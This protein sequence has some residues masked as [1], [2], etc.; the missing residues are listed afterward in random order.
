MQKI[1]FN[2]LF[3]KSKLK[4]LLTWCIIN[5]GQYNTLNL[6]ENLKQL[7][8]KYATIAGISLGIDD[9]KTIS[10]KRPLII[11]N[12]NNIQTINDYFELGIINEVDK[13]QYLINNWQKISEIL[14]NDINKK[15]KNVHRLNPIYMM[16]FSGAR[17][18][19]SQVRQLIG[20][21]GLM[22]DPNGQIIH[23]PITSNFREGL[24]V[25]E[26]LIS[27]YGARKGVVDTALRTA[28]AGYLT[29]RLVDT[30]QHVIISQL[31]CMTL[32]GIFLSNL[33]QNEN[34]ITSLQE[35]LYGRILAINL[36]S[37][38]KQIKLLRN[39]QIDNSLAVFL[40][41]NFK[42]IYVRSALNCQAS[43]LT[44]CQLCYG[45]NLSHLRLI[46]LGEVVG[47]VAAQSIGEPGTQLTMRT[48]H[49][50]GV[51]SGSAI[52]HLYAP[53]KGIVNYS[54]TLKGT[55][56]KTYDNKVLLLVQKTGLIILSPITSISYS[57]GKS[58]FFRE[59]SYKKEHLSKK[60][61]AV[62]YTMLFVKNKEIVEYN[63]LIAK[64]HTVQATNQQIKAVYYVLSKI[65]G[66]VF[67]DDSTIFRKKNTIQS[68]LLNK[69]ENLWILSGK[70]YKPSLELRLFP[71]TG[72]LIS[73][74]FPVA[75]I[76][77]LNTYPSFFRTLLINKNTII[78]SNFNTQNS[79]ALLFTD[80][81]IYSF[82][83]N[84]ITSMSQYFIIKPIP[85]NLTENENT[86]KIQSFNKKKYTFFSSS[87]F[88]AKR[89]KINI[90]FE[91]L[92]QSHT[93]LKQS[94]IA[95]Y[96]ETT[97]KENK[98]LFL[99][100]SNFL[101]KSD[102]KVLNGLIDFSILVS[103]KFY[104]NRKFEE[105]NYSSK[106]FHEDYLSLTL[107][108][109]F[110]F[111]DE[112]MFLKKQ[113]LN[114]FFKTS[115][116]FLTNN[117]LL[118]YEY[119]LVNEKN[120]LIFFPKTSLRYFSPNFLL[121]YVTHR[122]SNLFFSPTNLVRSRIKSS[123][124]NR[125]LFI[126]NTVKEVKFSSTNFFE[127]LLENYI[128]PF[129]FIF[130]RNIS[131]F[132]FFYLKE[133]LFYQ[134]LIKT[135]S[136][137]FLIS[138][139]MINSCLSFLER[140]G[141]FFYV[142]IFFQKEKCCKFLIQQVSYS[143]IL[144]NFED[145]PILTIISNNQL[146]NQMMI[147]MV[148]L[149]KKSS[150]L[151]YFSSFLFLET[152]KNCTF[153]NVQWKKIP[154]FLKSLPKF[155]NNFSKFNSIEL[156]SFLNFNILD[157]W[158]I[159]IINF[160]KWKYLDVFP[161]KLNVECLY[162]PQF[163][164]EFN[165][166]SKK[167]RFWNQ[168]EKKIVLK[169]YCFL[170][171]S[172]PCSFSIFNFLR[173]KSFNRKT[174]NFQQIFPTI[175]YSRNFRQNFPFEKKNKIFL[176]LN[177]HIVTPFYCIVKLI[178][179]TF[180]LSHTNYKKLFLNYHDNISNFLLDRQ[181]KESFFKDSLFL[182]YDEL[183]SLD[184]FLFNKKKSSRLSFSNFYKKVKV[185][186]FLQIPLLIQSYIYKYSYIKKF[187]IR[188]QFFSF[189]PLQIG[190]IITK[191][192]FFFPK[193]ETFT[194]NPRLNNFY[195]NL[196][197]LS[198]FFKCSVNNYILRRV[199]DNESLHRNLIDRILFSFHH[200]RWVPRGTEIATISFLSP[201]EGEILFSKFSKYSNSNI[202]FNQ[203]II[204][205]KDDINTVSIFRNR[206]QTT[207]IQK[208]TSEIRYHINKAHFVDLLIDVGSL[209]Y[210]TSLLSP[211]KKLAQSGQLV[212]F[213][214]D[215]CILRKGIP[216]LYPLNGLF[217]VWNGDFIYVNSPIMTLL[218]S[219][220]K[221]GDIVQGI[222]KIEHFF[223]ARKTL[224]GISN[225]LQSNIYFKLLVIF[226]QFKKQLSIKRA[227]KRSVAKIQKIIID[228]VLRVYC[229]QGISI[230]RKHFEVIIRQM[231]SKA[232]II[233]GGETGLIEGELI[234][235]YKIDKINTQISFKRI[236]Y[237]PIILGITKTSLK[238]D[239]FISS[240]SF[241]ETARVLS[242][243]AI[244]KKIDFLNGL[245]E[246][247]ILGRLIP[248]G[249]GIISSILTGFYG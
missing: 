238:T 129:L 217:Y 68:L 3:N 206:N 74:G 144:R 130:N 4:T 148:P 186:Y 182:F 137:D 109:N 91:K 117:F 110:V 1:F 160:L 22:A 202:F 93:F 237:E 124:S 13:S 168:L 15:F 225:G 8:F 224:K 157:G 61:E 44:I 97:S 122:Q 204:L 92:E 216:L 212:G 125:Q 95:E 87:S 211:G 72:D 65:E 26:Y 194:I 18:N 11:K 179:S 163:L 214:K 52:N 189:K 115:D 134:Q 121:R 171:V 247:V 158:M 166:V 103:K 39:K 248:G 138:V 10:T 48:F 181:F 96:S 88:C 12:Y 45:W 29:R 119:V 174:T 246:N 172:F 219:K 36:E 183:Y 146:R 233:D 46:S 85:L 223:E 200:L 86:I 16:A 57:K 155:E 139:I 240:A 37:N 107:N 42:R 143:L 203:L 226:M 177:F 131:N 142:S 35:Q 47:I 123:F 14:K 192:D 201:Y 55:T 164:R 80:C 210:S 19:I 234:S 20:M 67:I 9:F 32:K 94:K 207:L 27:C 31:D 132:L 70:I 126:S 222:P 30:A 99:F 156:E 25:T 242:Q 162:I 82:I 195:I 54:A 173:L 141:R 190:N 75:K 69:T 64:K 66:E 7:G 235:L 23:L 187:E 152:R 178:K 105:F 62:P 58:L 118:T 227:I 120:K 84:N 169:Y 2:S 198:L 49:T 153:L 113:H 231:T 100:P 114:I 60:F 90:N 196:R 41:K 228:G 229:S 56:I 40:S 167:F 108:N 53:F 150:I 199:F 154:F 185:S 28:T 6:A 73:I 98:S 175:F 140:F 232:K 170:H 43:N 63:Q 241:Q 209:L 245:K 244:E 81:P 59:K 78:S 218:Y 34:I 127:N 104:F 71:K 106:I 5:T 50:G 83:L 79:Q 76:K 208:Q 220:L 102:V 215:L 161:R 21:R 180:I 249:T 197:S 176:N 188:H 149:N 230:S 136:N 165:C 151:N 243:S 17:G 221:T 205:T 89:K 159:S 193:R 133:I 236:I 239:S 135:S 112:L 145:L 77:L 184:S 101:I 147:N 128:F 191:N 111:K 51:F 38:N 33:Y 116:F 24:T 213:I